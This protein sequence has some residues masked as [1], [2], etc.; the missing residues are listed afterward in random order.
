MKGEEESSSE[1]EVTKES[2][3]DDAESLLK[4]IDA[5][6][7]KEHHGVFE[8]EREG[9]VRRRMEFMK[10]AM[11]KQRQEARLEAEQLIQSL[12]EEKEFDQESE[13]EEEPAELSRE[14]VLRLNKIEHRY[15]AKQIEKF[16]DEQMTDGILET[17]R[18]DISDDES[19]EKLILAYDISM[20][21]NSRYR[22]Q[23]EEKQVQNG[24]YCYPKMTFSVKQKSIESERN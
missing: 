12:Q 15:T 5:D 1:E 18:M 23:V 7:K 2:L 9:N 3:L 16:I 24:N 10:R 6:K 4:E 19:F 14:D 11:E 20:R 8:C 21:K 17:D 13:E 22:V